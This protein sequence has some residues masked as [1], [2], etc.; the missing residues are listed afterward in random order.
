VNC[1]WAIFWL[2]TAGVLSSTVSDF[3]NNYGWGYS[4]NDLK[5][6]CAFS[7]LTFIAWLCSTVIGIMETLKGNKGAAAPASDAPAVAMV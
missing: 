1:L 3:N 6:S 5:A 7:W 2:S 4:G